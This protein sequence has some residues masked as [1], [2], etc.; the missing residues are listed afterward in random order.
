MSFNSSLVEMATSPITPIITHALDGEW[1]KQMLRNFT[2][3]LKKSLPH[4]L[5]LASFPLAPGTGPF[6]LSNNNTT[7]PFFYFPS[8]SFRIAKSVQFL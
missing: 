1:M 6:N 8:Y 7:N 4:I 2:S 5:L 3:S